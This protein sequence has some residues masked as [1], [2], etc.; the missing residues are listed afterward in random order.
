MERGSPAAE[1][2]LRGPNRV[3]IVGV[4]QIGIGG[5]LVVAVDGQP[6]E[7][8]DSLQRILNRKRVGDPLELTVFRSGRTQKV[9][10]KLGEAPQTM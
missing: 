8:N 5:D 1:A 10:V 3:A 9:R 6:V 4:Y 7:G 2:G